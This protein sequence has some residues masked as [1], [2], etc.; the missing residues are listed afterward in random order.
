MERPASYEI[1]VQG[2]LDAQWAEW[3][4]PLTL[5]VCRQDD[6][7]TVTT[8][9]GPAD[10]ARLHGILARIRDL[11]LVLLSVRRVEDSGRDG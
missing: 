1:T 9:R 10:Q 7:Q 5:S 4:A 8:L 2:Q 6:G 11:N 3:F